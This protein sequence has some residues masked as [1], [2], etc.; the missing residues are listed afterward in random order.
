MWGL[1]FCHIRRAVG[2]LIIAGLAGCGDDKGD[3]GPM[4]PGVGTPAQLA[5]AVELSDAEVNLPL[6]PTVQVT[7]QDRFGDMV[8]AATDPVTLVIGTNPGGGALSGTTT[9]DAVGGVANFTDLEI[10][11]TG[12]GYTLVASSGSL[13]AA[14]SA[15]FDLLFPVAS[16]GPGGNHTCGLTAGRNAYCW[17]Q[18]FRGQLGDGATT[19]RL[20]PVLVAGG[21]SFTS[22]SAG[23]NHTCGLTTGGDAYCWGFNRDGQLGDGTTTDR[24][25]PGLVSGGLSF[26]SLGAGNN[27]TCSVASSGDAYCWGSNDFSQLGDGSDTTRLTPRLVSGGLSF[28]WL[29]GG[30]AHTCG[31]TTGGNAYCWGINFR[32]Q[33]GDGTVTDRLTP[34]LVSGGLSFASL[35]AGG[36]HTCGQTAGGDAYC[37]GS[38]AFGELGDGTTS[39]RTTPVLVS[40]GLSLASALAGSGHTCALTIGGDAYCWGV[41]LNL[42]DGGA[43]NELCNG[44]PCS[45]VPVSVS[46]GLSFASLAVGSAQTCGATSGGDAYCW[47]F[48]E[49]GQVGDGTTTDRLMPVRVSDP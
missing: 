40:G 48:N 34:V 45:T 16:F 7:I 27:H 12:S 15:G 49:S 30:S 39:F 46:G 18:D 4:D 14:A 5:F 32:G 2:L 38:N 6:A 26:A 8:T 22:L 9:V 13:T 19:D 33:L 24:S 25:T 41:G 43:T 47:G 11:K 29:S 44:T 23:S 10:N 42:G 28:T 3:G 35:S 17:G 37:W 20:T 36:S 31:L 21:L 1:L